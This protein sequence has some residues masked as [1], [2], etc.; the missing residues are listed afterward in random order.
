[1]DTDKNKKQQD[2]KNGCVGCLSIVVLIVLGFAACSTLIPK[3]EYKISCMI[4]KGSTEL[5][6][7]TTQTLTN[8]LGTETYTWYKDK[9]IVEVSTMQNGNQTIVKVPAS[10]NGENLV[11]SQNNFSHIINTSNGKSKT[12]VTSNSP[13]GPYVMR[14]EGT[15]TGYK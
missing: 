14:F 15:C 7:G 1:M 6:D 5:S 10:L 3:T 8:N 9:K 11:F 12:T 13:D 2:V 4:E